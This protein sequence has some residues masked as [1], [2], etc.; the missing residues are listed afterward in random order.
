MALNTW[1]M[2]AAFGSEYKAQRMQAIREELRRGVHDI[3]LFEELWMEPDH[4]TVASGAP[5][6]FTV[7]GF[8]ELAKWDCDG[9]VAP[10]SCSGEKKKKEKKKS[11]F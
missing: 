9:R 10:T 1:G 7:T 11:E 3:Y 5:R 6:G 8:R 2:P 4:G